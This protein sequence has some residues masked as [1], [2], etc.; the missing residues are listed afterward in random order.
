[1]G[2]KFKSAVNYKE[3]LHKKL[4]KK[5]Y[6]YHRTVNTKCATFACSVTKVPEEMR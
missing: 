1:M 5:A 3:Q 4:N 6:K 2:F